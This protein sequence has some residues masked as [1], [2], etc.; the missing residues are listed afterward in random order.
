MH[1]NIEVGFPCC[2]KDLLISFLK[3]SNCQY[4]SDQIFTLTSNGELINEVSKHCV[5][6]VGMSA[7]SDDRN[8]MTS[9]CD[10]SKDQ[11]WT[12]AYWDGEYF[13]FKQPES[14][15][16]IDVAYYDGSG[17][18]GLFRCEGRPDQRWKWVSVL[19]Q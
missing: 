6:V 10:G 14:D 2:S 17:D 7:V 5:D 3:D 4:S 12:Q 19:E 18:I 8:I 13:S 15:L 1:V 16:C 9:V 11:K